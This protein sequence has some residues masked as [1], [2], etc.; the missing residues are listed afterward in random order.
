[1]STPRPQAG[2]LVLEELREFAERIAR[3]AGA[4]ALRYF[5]TD[6]KR[7][8][9]SDG[10]IV[11]QADRECERLLR[12][13]I[14]ERYPD[15][16]VLGEEHGASVGRSGRRWILDPIDGTFSFACGVPLFGTLVAVKLDGRPLVG[17]AHLPALEETVSAATGLGAA[18]N[19]VTA[20][21]SS[22]SALSKALVVC[23]DF[24]AATKHGL[25]EASQRLQAAARQ[26][27]GWGDCYGH[28]LVATGR[29]D[30]ALDPVMSIWDCA[31]LL[32][33]LEEAGGTF[34]DWRGQVTIDGGNAITTNGALLP[35]VVRLVRQAP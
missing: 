32:P 17:V 8:R 12:A 27:R 18:Y 3:E 14:Q 1:M 29:A 23:G 19:G 30:V 7:E 15:D 11:T 10:S 22:V 13:R 34:T 26:R 33:I 31:A 6:L 2:H 20:R 21:V 4:V 35:E 5:G 28:V 25:G 16:A 9:K 24:F